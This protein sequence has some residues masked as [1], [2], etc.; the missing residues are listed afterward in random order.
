MKRSI[1]LVA[2]VGNASAVQSPS[3]DELVMNDAA[4]D[5]IED[6]EEAQQHAAEDEDD[7][8]EVGMEVGEEGRGGLMEPEAAS[9]R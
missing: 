4:E 7:E 5:E 6:N 3:L 2:L 1:L 9:V 8:E